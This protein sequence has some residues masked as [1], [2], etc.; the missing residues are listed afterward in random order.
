M[1]EANFYYFTCLKTFKF[2]IIPSRKRPFKFLSMAAS[3]RPALE[4]IPPSPRHILSPSIAISDAISGFFSFASISAASFSA[5]TAPSSSSSSTTSSSA[6]PPRI[7]TR[8]NTRSVSRSSA[9]KENERSEDPS[10]VTNGQSTITNGHRH[11][12]AL[13]DS[14]VRTL[15]NTLVNGRNL[16]ALRKSLEQITS[17]QVLNVEVSP[18]LSC[19]TPS[20]AAPPNLLRTCLQTNH[21]NAQKDS[22]GSYNSTSGGS[23]VAFGSVN[24]CGDRDFN[25]GAFGSS[26]D[27]SDDSVIILDDTREENNNQKG[28]RDKIFQFTAKSNDLNNSDSVIIISPPD[29]SGADENVAE[30][31]DAPESLD[32][33]I[34]VTQHKVKRVCPITKLPFVNPVVNTCGHTYEKEA[35]MTMLWARLNKG[36]T[37]LCP[38]AGCQNSVWSRNLKRV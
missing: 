6:A 25:F 37:C 8:Y 10:P 22:Y 1:G 35:A 16:R 18:P 33:S 26:A 23:S 3:S 9:E 4:V 13:P 17:S 11:R 34:C 14:A 2:F 19:S 27:Q 21:S 20:K 32:D 31:I 29:L 28:G 5:L 12:Q 38:V 7:C 30:L 36:K 24:A 15:S